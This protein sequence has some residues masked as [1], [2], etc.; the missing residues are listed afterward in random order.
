MPLSQVGKLLVRLPCECESLP[1]RVVYVRFSQAFY[2][3]L[4]PVTPGQ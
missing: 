1:K 4:C 3:V 2:L